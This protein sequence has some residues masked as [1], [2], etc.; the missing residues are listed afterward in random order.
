MNTTVSIAGILKVSPVVLGGYTLV[1]GAGAFLITAA[2]L[3]RVF[4]KQSKIMISETIAGVVK[5][6]LPL[7]FI[8]GLIYFVLSNPLL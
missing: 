3:E 6:L 2:Y 4:A 7:G 5:I 1:L 8:A